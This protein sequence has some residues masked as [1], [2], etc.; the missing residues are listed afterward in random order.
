MAAAYNH[1]QLGVSV[2]GNLPWYVQFRVKLTDV[3][4]KE[5]NGLKVLVP[6]ELT[7]WNLYTDSVYTLPE[8]E[9][10]TVTMPVP[11]V[12]IDGE[13]TVFH[14]K[15]DGSVETIKPVIHG[16]MMSFET[17]SFSPFSVAGSTLIAGIGIGSGTPGNSGNNSTNNGNSPAGNAPSKN[18][19][20]STN[21]STEKTYNSPE[22]RKSVV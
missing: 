16:N 14:Y 13:F 6:Y 5:E 17:S 11:D 10:V 9:T 1:T 20:P 22:D 3:G 8:G 18:D 2:Y 7:L 19:A 21:S 4:K 15:A 12:E